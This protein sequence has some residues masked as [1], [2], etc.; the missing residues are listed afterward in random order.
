[1][2]PPESPPAHRVGQKP[3]QPAQPMSSNLRNPEPRGISEILSPEVPMPQTQA[4]TGEVAQ[5]ASVQTQA[6]YNFNPQLQAGKPAE[7]RPL[8]T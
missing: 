7:H 3:V 1:M 6:V 5:P 4:E 8:L 2:T